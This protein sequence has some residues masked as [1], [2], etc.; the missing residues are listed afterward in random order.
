MLHGSSRF[1]TCPLVRLSPTPRGGRLLCAPLCLLAGTG[2]AATPVP[3]LTQVV[4]ACWGAGSLRARSC[5]A[6]AHTAGKA[7]E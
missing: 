5:A 3:S 1:C 6:G 4:V 2:L 7:F